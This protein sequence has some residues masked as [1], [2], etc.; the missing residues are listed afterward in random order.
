MND[1]EQEIRVP[2]TVDL[3]RLSIDELK[4]RIS[5]LQSEIKACE[6]QLEKKANQLT[7]ANSLFGSDD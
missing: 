7:A 6:A 1:P 4:E 2:E 3:E 5:A